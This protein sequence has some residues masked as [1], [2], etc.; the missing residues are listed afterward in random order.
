MS[1]STTKPRKR[2]CW[3]VAGFTIRRPHAAFELS[4]HP[5]GKW[6]KRILTKLY[7]F[8]NWATKV[9]GKL[10]PLPDWGW[11]AAEDEYKK[12]A[13]DLHAGRDRQ[14]NNDD[15]NVA[16][17]CNAF[18]TAM[19]E[20]RDAGDRM[21]ARMFDDYKSTTDR[22]VKAPPVGV[23][24]LTKVSKL[25]ATDFAA[26]M[27]ALRQHFGPLRRGREVQKVKTVFNWAYDNEVIAAKP[28]F[29]DFKKPPRDEVRKHRAKQAPKLFTAE[30]VRR[31]IKAASV[32]L[33]AMTLL[34]I[35]CGYGNTDCG[36]LPLSAIDLKR[37][38]ATF[39]RPK[40]GLMRRAKLWPETVKAIKAVLAKRKEPAPDSPAAGLLF[41]TRFGRPWATDSANVIVQ[42]FRRLLTRLGINGRENLGFYSLRHTF[43]TVADRVN[44]VSAVRLCMG[45]IDDSIDA[46]YTHDTP[47]NSARLTAVSDYVRA[48]V[49]AKGGAK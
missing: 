37:G 15:P 3:Q 10:V 5:S 28:R 35:N 18:L 34:G 31:I 16:D 44:D 24:L 39:P 11:K 7:Y 13:S 23:G 45:H 17:L 12:E 30:E 25:K 2:K 42:A 26:M 1:N 14:T 36:K 46:V 49:F 43:R 41:V 22:L 38:W 20:R 21:S 32:S 6:Q 33:R 8:G 27:P 4:P 48:W 9:N 40:T 47:E 19:T 29:G